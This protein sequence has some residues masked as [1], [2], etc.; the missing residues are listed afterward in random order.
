MLLCEIEVSSHILI[1]LSLEIVTT[2]PDWLMN[3][4]DFM[5]WLCDLLMKVYY[6]LSIFKY[7]VDLL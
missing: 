3:S 2:L 7:A 5:V 1:V 4:I 6:P